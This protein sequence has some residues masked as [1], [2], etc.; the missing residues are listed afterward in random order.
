MS[1]RSFV[2]TSELILVYWVC[3][4]ILIINILR[5]RSFGDMVAA[6]P[7]TAAVVIPISAAALVA[8]YVFFLPFAIGVK[9]RPL[10]EIVKGM[11]PLIVFWAGVFVGLKAFAWLLRKSIG[12]KDTHGEPVLVSPAVRTVKVL[13]IMLI[14]FLVV[15]FRNP[16]ALLR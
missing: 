12:S 2:F 15:V 7:E 11:I 4:L 16:A 1:D 3:M 9:V 8:I 14:V 13:L 5:A 10:A 6:I